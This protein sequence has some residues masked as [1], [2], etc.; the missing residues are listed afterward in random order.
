[1]KRSFCLLLCLAMLVSCFAACGKPEEE[2]VHQFATTWTSN[3]AMH[4]NAATCEHT[5]EQANVALHTDANNDGTCDVCNYGS[6]HVHT[7]SK[8]T[9]APTCTEAGIIT[10]CK[11][12]QFSKAF[13]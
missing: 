8:H 13:D 11:L 12:I 6:D 1:M 10:F 5:N 9:T 4:W 7:Y 3:Q 2:H